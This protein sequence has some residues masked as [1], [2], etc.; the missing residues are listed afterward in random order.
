M[1]A[2]KDGYLTIQQQNIC[3]S[4][5]RL[6]FNLDSH[7]MAC[8]IGHP[9]V[10]LRFPSPLISPLSSWV[11]YCFSLLCCILSC[12]SQGLHFHYLS[13]YQP[14]SVV[15]GWCLLEHCMARVGLFLQQLEHASVTGTGSY[16]IDTLSCQQQRKMYDREAVM[17]SR[18][19]RS[20]EGDLLV[21]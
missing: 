16:V 17:R 9:A 13:T 12:S 3:V 4:R 18:R 8:H 19:K 11:Q 7:C 6:T 20:W 5:Y 10:S 21:E 1:E 2:E 15:W 14:A